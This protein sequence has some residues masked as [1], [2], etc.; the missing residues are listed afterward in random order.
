MKFI[1]EQDLFWKYIKIKYYTNGGMRMKRKLQLGYAVLVFALVLMLGTQM[2]YASQDP[3]DTLEETTKAAAQTKKPAYKVTIKFKANGGTGSMEKQVVKSGKQV[4]LSKNAFKNGSCKFIGW[5]LEAN[6][7]VK[8]ENH[9]DASKLAT[10]ENDG[11]TI[12]LY[13]QWKLPAP[14]LKKVTSKTPS[15]IDIAFNKVNGIS[16]YRI[17]YSTDKKFKKNVVVETAGKKETSARLFQVKPG[18][19]YFVRI[20]CYKIKGYTEVWTSDWSSV[21]SVQ[22]KNGKTLMNTKAV[23]GIE[24]DVKL[25][26]SGSGYHAKLVIGTPTSAV[27]FGMQYDVGAANPYGSRNMALIE[28]VASNAPG[29]QQ[30][31]RP[32]DFEFQLNKV[33]HLMITCDAKGNGDVY[34]DYKRI[35][36]FSQPNLAKGNIYLWIEVSGRLNGDGVDAE[37]ANIQSKDRYYGLKTIKNTQDYQG[38]RHDRTN[39]GLK[40]KYNK[41]TNTVRLYGNITNLQ[42]DWDSAYNGVSYVLHVK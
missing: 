28:N 38:C 10:E 14:K 4:K 9:A 23:Y 41:K 34:V 29:G 8:Y 36:G 20:R 15:Y 13:A 33:Y 16:G 39:A 21:S 37:F 40:C 1:V 2:T 22:V 32:S 42:G 19:K 18:K 30:Y 24:A 27:S 31:V 3:T 5:S 26:G 35:G 25:N 12:T 7:A 11:E 6:G 17:E